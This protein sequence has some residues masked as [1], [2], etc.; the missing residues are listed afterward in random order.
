MAVQLHQRI[1]RSATEELLVR[2]EQAL[3]SHKSLVVAVVE[4]VR[5]PNVERG[6]AGVLA[7][8]RAGV[9]PQACELGVDAALVV[10]A[11]AEGGALGLADGVAAGERGHVPCAEALGGEH[12]DELR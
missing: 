3:T 10:D 9:T 7:R 11:S 6:E 2:V 4:T 1:L 5:S 12:G 8:E